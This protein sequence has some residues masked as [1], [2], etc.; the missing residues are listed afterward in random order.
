MPAAGAPAGSRRGP[1]AAPRRHTPGASCGEVED[2][3]HA[4]AEGVSTTGPAGL[5]TAQKNRKV[6]DQAT[7]VLWKN[8][9]SAGKQAVQAYGLRGLPRNL[10]WGYAEVPLWWLAHESWTQPSMSRHY[11]TLDSMVAARQICTPTY[12]WMKKNPDSIWAIVLSGP[13]GGPYITGRVIEDG[14]HR[15]GWYLCRH[16]PET[17]IPVVWGIH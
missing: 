15:F 8:L 6:M 10:R 5:L 9:P 14:H 16:H 2:A 4:R 3:G 7:G 13:P 17:V 11:P 12:Q 1:S